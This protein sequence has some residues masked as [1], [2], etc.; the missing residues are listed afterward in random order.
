MISKMYTEVPPNEEEQ[1]DDSE[2]DNSVQKIKKQKRHIKTPAQQV[3]ESFHFQQEDEIFVKHA[4]FTIKYQIKNKVQVSDSKRAF[5]EVGIEPHRMLIVL[6]R[7]KLEAI[8]ADITEF[9]KE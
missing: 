3:L 6:K 1:E 5:Q 4:E 7:S 8:L 2:N 9:V